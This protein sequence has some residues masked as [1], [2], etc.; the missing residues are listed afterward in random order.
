MEVVLPPYDCRS[1]GA[2]IMEEP[3]DE[4]EEGLFLVK[5]RRSSVF[6]LFLKLTF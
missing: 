3:L 6:F 2:G 1:L 4:L 5:K